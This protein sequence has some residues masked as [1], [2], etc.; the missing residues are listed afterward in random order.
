MKLHE[1][2]AGSK[3]RVMTDEGELLK[4][5]EG[6]DLVLDFTRSEGNYWMCYDVAGNPVHIAAWADVEVLP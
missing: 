3:I 4:D 5:R 6:N 1:V 2:Q